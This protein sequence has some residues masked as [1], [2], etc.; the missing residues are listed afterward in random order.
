[1]CRFFQ[2]L[3]RLVDLSVCNQRLRQQPPVLDVCGIRAA[4]T[5]E[6]RDGVCGVAHLQVND[7]Q[8]LQRGARVEGGG[9][10][11]QERVARVGEAT[12]GGVERAHQH[13]AGRER[14]AIT[15]LR[16]L[17]LAGSQAVLGGGGFSVNGSERIGCVL[18][19]GRRRADGHHHRACDPDPGERSE[20]RSVVR[21]FYLS[22]PSVARYVAR[23]FQASAFQASVCRSA[24][25]LAL[26]TAKPLASALD[27]TRVLLLR[28]R[29][30]E[31]LEKRTRLGVATFLP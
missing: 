22:E 3:E 5:R 19:A 16:A 14:G 2:L 13:P 29:S 30:D 11:P 4:Q 10:R 25:S 23:A 1:M 8:R 21:R 15:A 17:E 27:L 9:R 28:C 12:L 18:C 20:H 24:E 31:Q 7:R 26:R 6:E